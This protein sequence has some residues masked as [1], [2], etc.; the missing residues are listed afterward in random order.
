MG[1]SNRFALIRRVITCY[2]Y[3]WAI[4]QFWIATRDPSMPVWK[5]LSPPAR[6]VHTCVLSL[7]RSHCSMYFR[8]YDLPRTKY[9]SLWAINLMTWH[10]IQYLILYV[11]SCNIVLFNTRF[12]I[13][14]LFMNF[15]WLL[16]RKQ[17]LLILYV[18]NMQ[19]KRNINIFN[20]VIISFY[21]GK[22]IGAGNY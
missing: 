1:V 2:D 15:M 11:S 9:A 5:L 6:H 17:N 10:H 21:L 22:Q 8:L 13:I 14:Y 16:I 4:Y 3:L 20:R 7:Y 19:L 12:A 18:I